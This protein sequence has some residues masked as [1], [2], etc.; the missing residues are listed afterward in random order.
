MAIINWS[1]MSKLLVYAF[2]CIK[3][4][5]TDDVVFVGCALSSCPR[6]SNLVVP[7]YCSR[8]MLEG[9]S[10]YA[11]YFMPF[12]DFFFSPK[13]ILIIDVYLKSSI[14]LCIWR[15]I[16]ICDSIGALSLFLA[17]SVLPNDL[18]TPK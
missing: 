4:F 3:S 13:N 6:S 14:F 18:A 2:I 10:G 5:F 9:D 16:L 17:F 12:L 11:S 1:L 8:N 15:A 7:L